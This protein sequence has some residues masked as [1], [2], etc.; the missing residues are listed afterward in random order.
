MWGCVKNHSRYIRPLC[1]T[2]R[3]QNGILSIGKRFYSSHE[4]GRYPL[5]RKTSW[6][7]KLPCVLVDTV[8]GSTN[9]S[10]RY[11][12]SMQ[13]DPDLSRDFFVQLWL[14]DKKKTGPT[15]KRRHKVFKSDN[16]GEPV[17]DGRTLIEKM[18]SGALD[19]KS[20]GKM[21]S[22]LK[23]PPTSQS[24]TGTLEP[25]SLEEVMLS[26]VTLEHIH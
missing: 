6:M 16:I 13:N 4:R 14:A 21:K 22:G 17:V 25:M 23:Q 10:L 26:C 5:E 8:F 18:L 15:A 24:I 2:V 12:H 7:F 9:T 19:E 20:Y 1:R 3:D 11:V